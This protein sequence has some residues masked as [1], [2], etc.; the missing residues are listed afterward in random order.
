MQVII[1]SNFET[2]YLHLW[3]MIYSMH[4]FNELLKIK[5]RNLSYFFGT[6]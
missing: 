5:A 3:N 1:C 2:R 6:F 4:S